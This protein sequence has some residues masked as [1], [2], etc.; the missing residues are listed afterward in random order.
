MLKLLVGCGGGNEETLLVTGSQAADDAG[1]GDCGVADRNDILK[2]GFEDTGRWVSS[3]RGVSKEGATCAG[4]RTRT[5]TS[6]DSPVEVLGSAYCDNRIGIGK[7]G[8][9][10]NSVRL[11][12]TVGEVQLPRSVHTRW[13][14]Q[15]ARGQP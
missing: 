10:T 4:R 12:R 5:R 3:C 9:D 8:K 14:S 1:S 13:S 2:F 6:E 15:T 7:S 11:V